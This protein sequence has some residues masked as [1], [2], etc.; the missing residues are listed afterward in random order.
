MPTIKTKAI[1]FSSLK[2]GDSNLIVKCFTEKEGLKSYFLRGVL[3]TKKGKL[4]PAYF[5]PLTQLQIVA[6]HNNKENLNSLKEVQVIS[7]YETIPNNIIKQTIILFL[8][9][10]LSNIIREEEQNIQ[11]FNY[12]ETTLIWLDTHDSIANFHLL[13]LLN[14]SRFLGFYPN[15][16]QSEK[17]VFNL[18]EGNFT[19]NL[20]KNATISGDQLLQF[21]KLLGINFDAIEKVSFSKNQR[22][23]VL[24]IIIRYFELHLEGFRHPKSL[25]ILK[26]IFS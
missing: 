9:E 19:D 11:L 13:F 15:T 21:K 22:Q 3:K 2:Y 8:S 12:L 6:N 25:T 5:Q 7:N 17:P 20:D 1:V 4:K 14:L 26:T 18:L 16:S 10:V 23:Q 24:Q